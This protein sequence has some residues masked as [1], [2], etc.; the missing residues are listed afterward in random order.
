MG[1]GINAAA[2]IVHR[3][4]ISNLEDWMSTNCPICNKDDAIQKLSVIVASGKSSGTFSGPS[5][6]AAYVDGKLVP[7]GGYSTLSGSTI[8]DLAKR[9][10]PPSEPQKYKGLGC[11]LGSLIAIVTFLG[12]I[13]AS[14]L[15]FLLFNVVGGFIFL[16]GGF[17]I[18]MLVLNALNKK[19]RK[20]DEAA[21]L[22]EKPRWDVAISRWNRS[23]FCHRD[24]IVFD[25]DTQETC[26]PDDL[27]GF[28]YSP[29]QRSTIAIPSS[30]QASLKTPIFPESSASPP[31]VNSVP[32]GEQPGWDSNNLKP[33]PT[34]PATPTA[35]P[36]SKKK[37]WKVV[38]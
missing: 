15:G 35:D 38:G 20:R 2:S 4:A 22:F 32:P 34:I 21:Y 1:Q 30:P 36:A 11:G 19:S 28:L 10:T 17:V 25:P 24:G 14:G 8:S 27:S 26:Q 33:T 18:Y 16:F 37:S 6:G 13:A 23:Y 3:R 5:G 29:S 12:L 9:L 31:V 7:M